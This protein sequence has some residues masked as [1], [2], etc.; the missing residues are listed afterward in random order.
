MCMYVRCMCDVTIHACHSGPVHEKAVIVKQKVR[1]SLKT[2]DETVTVNFVPQQSNVKK[3]F[4]VTHSRLLK[5]EDLSSPGE[6][7]GREGGREE[8]EDSVCYK[9]RSRRLCVCVCVCV[10]EC[11]CRLYQRVR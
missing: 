3:S 4:P 8:R 10:C 5:E 2:P 9:I 6:R 11:V 7:G 1:K